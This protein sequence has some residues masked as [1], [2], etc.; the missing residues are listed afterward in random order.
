VELKRRNGGHTPGGMLVWLPQKNVLISGDIVHV[1][2]T[3]GLLPVG[4]SKA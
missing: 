1:D 4:R 2:R 3:L